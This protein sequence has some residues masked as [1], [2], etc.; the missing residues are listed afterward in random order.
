MLYPDGTTPPTITNPG[1]GTTTDPYDPG[2]D[3]PNL[4]TSNPHILSTCSMCPCQYVVQ[5]SD[6]LPGDVVRASLRALDLNILQSRSQ[7]YRL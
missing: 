5:A 4:E 6:L 1:S 7:D 2:G 3:N